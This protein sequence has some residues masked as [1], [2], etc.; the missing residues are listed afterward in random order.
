MNTEANIT[1][2]N[3]VNC[4]STNDSITIVNGFPADDSVLLSL[5]AE[6][7]Y[8]L[9]I[10]TSLHLYFGNISMPV[11]VFFTNGTVA[12]G[13]SVQINI[14]DNA[15]ISQHGITNDSGVVVFQS[16]P[17]TTISLFAHTVDNQIGL[18]GVSPSSSELHVTLIPLV[19]G[20]DIR[21]RQQTADNNKWLSVDTHEFYDLQ[22]QTASFTSVA[23][24]T[25]VYAEYQFV[26][27]EVPGG[28]FGSQFNDYF[29]VTLRSSTGNY[30]T[31]SQSMNSL[32]LGAFD[33]ASGATNWMN[34]TMLVGPQPEQI[35]IVMGVS[36]VADGLY[37]S[38]L[39]VDKYGSDTCN[40]TC[41][42]D[43]NNQCT[44]DPMCSSTCLNPPMRSCL[45]YTNCME[46]K[47]ACSSDG[48]ALGYGLKYCTKFDHSANS[49]SSK[50]QT[51]LYSAMNCLQK[52]LI[53]PLKNCEKNCQTL[54]KIAFDSH[55]SC[56]VDNGV[57][58]LPPMDWLMLLPIINED[59]WTIDG[60]KQ[61]I[62]T[63]P[64]CVPTMIT[65]FEAAVSETLDSSIATALLIIRKWLQ[66]L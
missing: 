1:A 60:F 51:W 16:I 50:G 35:H 48:Y 63:V 23:N 6:D 37:P 38:Q 52:A 20:H 62:K 58:E 29:S 25:Q 12:S 44:S 14:T 24:A 2:L 34:L 8:G 45:F 11:R 4:T 32:G 19:S 66:T 36:N 3:I 39:N 22:T 15:R 64:Q 21:K 18:A 46:A 40:S 9:P 42:K 61:A 55:P 27:T 28:Y 65:R 13:V 30:K 26:T 49:F 47:T 56:Y 10:F 31:V 17:P 57:C 33:Y 5:V 54:K 43:C 53:S 41:N 59:L 7:I